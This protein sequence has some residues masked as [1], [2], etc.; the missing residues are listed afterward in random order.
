MEYSDYSNV[1]LA[2][3]VTELSE[4]TRMNEHTI[5]LE[6]SKQPLFRLIYSLGLVELETLKTYIEINLVNGFI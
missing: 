5:E 1:F 2:K 6:E 4:N 3:N